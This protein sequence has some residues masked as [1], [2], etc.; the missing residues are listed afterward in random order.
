MNDFNLDF[1]TL[2]KQI[3][4]LSNSSTIDLPNLF[5]DMI[6]HL[7]KGGKIYMVSLQ[8]VLKE[9]DKLYKNMLDLYLMILMQLRYKRRELILLE[10]LLNDIIIN[11]CD[12]RRSKNLI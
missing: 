3:Q 2:Q 4:K 11:N 7:K 1:K 10:M 5:I 9:L 8:L 6:E 12:F